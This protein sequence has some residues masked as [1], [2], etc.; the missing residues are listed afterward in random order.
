MIKLQ[1]RAG[2]AVGGPPPA[3]LKPARAFIAAVSAGG[4]M[5]ASLA[6][7]AERNPV[8]EAVQAQCIQ[9][10]MLRGFVGEALKGYVNACAEVKRNAPPP[11]LKQ[12][13]AEPAAC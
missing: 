8:L 12:F 9:E 5:C 1:P 2:E 3:I 6:V 11:D 13:S 4:I 10:G 7:A